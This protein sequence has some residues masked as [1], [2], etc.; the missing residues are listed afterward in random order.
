MLAVDGSEDDVD[1]TDDGDYVGD[2][3]AFAHGLQSLK[4]GEAGVAHVHAVGFDGAV[5]DDVVPVQMFYDGA[6]ETIAHA[7]AGRR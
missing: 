4:G 1:G 2:E 3:A 6:F 7:V 5:G